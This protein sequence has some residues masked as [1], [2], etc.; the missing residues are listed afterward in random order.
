MKGGSAVGRSVLFR[1]TQVG[2][3]APVLGGLQLTLLSKGPVSHSIFVSHCPLVHT[4]SQRH[5]YL[6]DLIVSSRCV[7][8]NSVIDVFEAGFLC[9]PDYRNTPYV[10]QTVP[11]L[12]EILPHLSTE[13]WD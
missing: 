3:L 6:K 10:D 2:F 9:S 1:E 4:P 11:K 13:C 8:C 5:K 7:D 12:I